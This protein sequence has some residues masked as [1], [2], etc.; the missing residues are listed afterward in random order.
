MLQH[1]LADVD[2]LFSVVDDSSKTYQNAVRTVQEIEASHRAFALGRKAA[3]P[4]SFIEFSPEEEAQDRAD[5]KLL[6]EALKRARGEED[7]DEGMMNWR[8]LGRQY[9][10]H[11]LPSSRFL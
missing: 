5:Q 4:T 9:V 6:W 1:Y 7:K 10:L 2:V 3:F 11:E 8:T